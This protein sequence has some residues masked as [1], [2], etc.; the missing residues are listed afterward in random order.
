MEP[1]F[2]IIGNEVKEQSR[3]KEPNR[4]DYQFGGSMDDKFK[5][6]YYHDCEKYEQHLSS[7]RTYIASPELKERFGDNE[8]GERDFEVKNETAGFDNENWEV[9]YVDVAYPYPVS[10]EQESQEGV[11]RPVPVLT[12]DKAGSGM[13]TAA[14]G[15]FVAQGKNR[16]EVARSIGQQVASH[17]ATMEARIFD[18]TITK[19]K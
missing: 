9:M 11:F 4:R 14:Y 12:F 1:I 2:K 17:F 7:L 18:Y 16:A 8:F 19:N 5:E 15:M 6:K 3:E 13:W 10:Q